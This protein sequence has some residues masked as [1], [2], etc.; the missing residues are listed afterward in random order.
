MR[1][2]LYLFFTSFL[3]TL[4]FGTLIP[5]APALVGKFGGTASSIG[6]LFAAYSFSRFVA[7]PF[8]GAQC[9]NIGRKKV[10]MISLTGAALGYGGVWFATSMWMLAACWAVVG[11]TDG[12]AAATY[13]AAADRTSSAD[14]S[15]VFA[16]LNAA[17]GLG[18]VVGPLLGAATIDLGPAAPFALVAAIYASA[19]LATYHFM[20]ETRPE[21]VKTETFSFRQSNSVAVLISQL[22]LPTIRNLLIGIFL[23]WLVVMSVATNLAS[24]IE[25]KTDWSP[26]QVAFLFSARGVM[27]VLLSAL[28]VPFVV[29][30][31]GEAR[32]ALMGGLV[33]GTGAILIVAFAWTTSAAFVFA[34]VL[35]FSIGQPHLQTSLIGLASLATPEERQGKVQGAI[36]GC[37]SSA[38]ITGP[39]SAGFLA[40][41]V[42][43]ASPYM[44]SA[45]AAVIAGRLG[46]DHSVLRKR[47]SE[48]I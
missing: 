5:L 43:P 2:P 38:E 9:D 15:R 32:T 7:T 30:R 33:V 39:L 29:V 6:L 13:A 34:G 14:R 10:L 8:W 3:I 12:M 41:G 17:S 40:E 26:E 23:M 35:L 28:V 45:M 18:F 20:P 44:L 31:L 47:K 46:W 16:R 27:D 4:G 36:Q 1:F 22:R 24:L 42:S 19:I 21:S 11:L 37:Q 48:W 25:I